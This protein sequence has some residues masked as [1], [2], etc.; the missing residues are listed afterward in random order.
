MLKIVSLWS[1]WKIEELVLRTS[2]SGKFT[3]VASISQPYH[4]NGRNYYLF[5]V[6]KSEKTWK[7][8]FPKIMALCN[9]QFG[10][11][12]P[13][14]YRMNTISCGVKRPGCGVNHPPPSSAKVKERS[15]KSRAIRLLLICAFTAGFI[16][17]FTSI[18][19]LYSAFAK[20]LGDLVNVLPYHATWSACQR[21]REKTVGFVLSSMWIWQLVAY[22]ISKATRARAEKYVILIA[23]SRQ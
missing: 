23:F 6:K 12:R 21:E 11:V 2:T 5:E 9:K 16:D 19:S 14:S 4:R 10:I 13:T 3:D 8:S 17:N 1:F 20:K 18:S 15:K 22:R 7:S